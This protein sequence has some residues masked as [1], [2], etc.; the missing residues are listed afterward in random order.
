MEVDRGKRLGNQ[1]R[2][3]DLK[4]DQGDKLTLFC[5]H[6]AVELGALQARNNKA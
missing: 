5:S 6:D 1:E 2:L 4:R 3:R